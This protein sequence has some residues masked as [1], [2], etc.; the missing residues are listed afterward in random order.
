MRHLMPLT[1]LCLCLSL[2][3][4]AENVQGPEPT[5]P[6]PGLLQKLDQVSPEGALEG[7]GLLGGSV[8]AVLAFFSAR[9]KRILAEVIEHAF[10]VV[11]DIGREKEGDDNFDKAAKALEA[12]DD[13]MKAHGWRPLSPQE[14]KIA[15]LE[16]KAFHGEEIAKQKVAAAG[17]EAAV[18]P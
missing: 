1:L 2:P 17:G 13:W 15:A 9:R 16:L 12:A 7:L 8:I 18:A 6:G 11:E 10:H 14:Q 5:P 4:S 3:A